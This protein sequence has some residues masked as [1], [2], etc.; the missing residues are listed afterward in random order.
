MKRYSILLLLLISAG[1]SDLFTYALVSPSQ[2]KGI[3]P[4]SLRWKYSDGV[5]TEIPVRNGNDDIMRL[6]VSPTTILFVRTTEREEHHFRLSSVVVEDKGEGILGASTSWKGY[7]TRQ[8]AERTVMIREVMETKIL[9]REPAQ[10]RL[11]TG[12]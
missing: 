9:S 10:E 8:G 2:V 5:V 6:R 11:L 3:H 1:C 4:D 7:D 12:Q